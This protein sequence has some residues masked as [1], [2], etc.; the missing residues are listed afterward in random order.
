MH[1]IFSVKQWRSKPV[2]NT[3]SAAT[4][5]A[6]RGTRLFRVPKPSKSRLMSSELRGQ[7]LPSLPPTP[8]PPR[9]SKKRVYNP[10]HS[11]Y[12]P[13]TER[14][15]NYKYSQFEQR[16]R[17]DDGYDTGYGHGSGHGGGHGSGRWHS[18]HNMTDHSAHYG[19]YRAPKR[20]S[21]AVSGHYEAS[22]RRSG[23]GWDGD[24][25]SVHK[26][27]EFTIG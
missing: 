7:G 27:S 11:K 13:L 2:P 19:S 12:A 15:D 9:L 22:Y 14:D 4:S 25:A 24:S 17:G 10:K 18:G 6:V 16:K 26:S 1:F 20:D 8:S 3:T 23:G 21:A 5:T